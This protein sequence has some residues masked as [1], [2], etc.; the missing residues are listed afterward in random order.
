MPAFSSPFRHFASHQIFGRSDIAVTG[1]FVHAVL[2]NFRVKT[3]V[4]DGL[5]VWPKHKRSTTL[6]FVVVAVSRKNPRI[7]HAL[8][9]ELPYDFIIAVPDSESAVTP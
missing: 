8:R 2:W 4:E 6:A 9:I 3:S 7:D 5:L 1:G